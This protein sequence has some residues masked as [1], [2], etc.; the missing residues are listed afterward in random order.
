M[1]AFSSPLIALDAIVLDTETTGLDARTARL[2]QIGAVRLASGA[3]D[4]AWSLDRLIAP[5]IPIPPAT[6]AVH[7]IDDS[8]VAQAPAFRD[9]AAEVQA[10]L[11]GNLVI[12]HTI[13]YDLAVL[14]REAT[15]A[16]APWEQPRTLDVRHL[17]RVAAPSLAHYDLDRLCAWLAVENTARHT[18]MGDA[19]ATAQVFVKLVPKLRER[20]VRTIAEAE[21]A[22]RREAE[23]EGQSLGVMAPGLEPSGQAASVLQ[24]IDSFPYRHRIADVMSAPPLVIEAA[25]SVG[26]AIRLLV[27]RKTSSAFVQDGSRVGIVTE[28]DLL[29]AVAAD[30]A[31]AAH[32][33]PVGEIMKAPLVTVAHD[34]FVYR[35]IGRIERHGIRHLGVVDAQGR[36]VGAVTTRNLLRHRATS[37]IVL[38]DEID[39][40][41][42]AAELASAWAKLTPMARSLVAEDVDARLVAA[43]VSA[44]VCSIT[45]RSAVLAERVMAGEGQGTAPV[46]YC[47]LVLGS[48]GRGES[49]LAADQDNAIVFSRGEPDGTEDRWFAAMAQHMTRILDEAGVPLCKGGVMASNAAWRMSEAGWRKAVDQWVSRQRPTDLL[50]TDIFFDA[51][52]V[53]GDLDLG[54]RV[55]DYA[56]T[57]GGHAHDFVK[58]I[59][60][61]A[62][63]WRA[64]LTMLGNIRADQDGRAELKKGG[65]LPIFTGARALALKHQIRVRSTPERLRAL[66]DRGIASADEIEAIADAHRRLL[67]TLLAQQLTD[68]ERGVPLSNRVDVARL[69]R[70]SR[71]EL[72]AALGKVASLVDIVGE[73][74]L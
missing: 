43:V 40:A 39:R 56:W 62:R 74:R 61:L 8:M 38:G 6:T 18:A 32:T 19:L 30:D 42:S 41:D 52:P 24:V 9:I 36:L 16:G 73:G 21:A 25:L 17:A 69:D 58:L 5:G 4:P 60:E 3:V 72:K 34:D 11:A 59:C 44:E 13:A 7:G 48:A 70:A 29:R 57:S 22:S 46:P 64:P 33:R 51:V 26:A 1:T 67:G 2:V 55:V 49:L 27:E 68:A 71:A 53:H 50:D 14:Q 15:L 54:R 65:L 10:L 35:A 31:G 12:G 45:A 66:A 37:A 20:G 63:D 23:R 47:V 28:R